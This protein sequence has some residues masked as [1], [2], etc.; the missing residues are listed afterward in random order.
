MSRSLGS[1]LLTT[2]AVDQ[3][4]P[5][6]MGF[7]PTATMRSSV[8]LPQPEGPTITTN[9]PSAM[10]EIDTVDHVHIAV[11]LLTCLNSTG[12]IA[13]TISVPSMKCIPRPGHHPS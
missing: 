5:P 12:A 8:D 3:I 9:S 7:K 11:G 2:L 4:S 13:N 6:V 10:L 1:R